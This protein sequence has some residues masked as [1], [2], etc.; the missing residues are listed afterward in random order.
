[1]KRDLLT[2]PFRQDQLKQRKGNLGKTVTY[3]E[4]ASVIERLNEACDSWDFEVVKYEAKDGEAIVLG[5]LTADGVTKMA[6]GG[7]SITVDKE[8]SIVS[9]A[10]DLKSAMADAVKKAASMLGVGLEL[11][12]G[13]PAAE[14]NE[15]RPMLPPQGDPKNRAT[16]R[17]MAALQSAARRRGLTQDR[18][19]AMVRARTGKTELAL[20]DRREAST[21]ISELS[22]SNGTS[23]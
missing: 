6:F 12:G 22:G 3:V 11:Y 2:R 14:P 21:L 20:L 16:V 4:I 17:Q 5:K 10:D 9:L 13:K 23:H 1:M 7:A 19:S 15:S 18:L 8:G